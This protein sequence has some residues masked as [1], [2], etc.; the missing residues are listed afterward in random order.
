[1]PLVN[2]FLLRK[3]FLSIS[4]VHFSA[5]WLCLLEGTNCDFRLRLTA[6]TW[7]IKLSKGV[8]WAT[9][10]LVYNNLYESL[11]KPP[12]CSFLLKLFNCALVLFHGGN[13]RKIL[14]FQLLPFFINWFFVFWISLESTRICELSAT[15]G[16]KKVNKDKG[17][18]FWRFKYFSSILW[19]GSKH[20]CKAHFAING[21]SIAGKTTHSKSVHKKLVSEAE[22]GP[23]NRL[24]LEM[25]ELRADVLLLLANFI[26]KLKVLH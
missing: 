1:M 17:G 12:S 24:L 21:L 6:E 2:W 5:S 25:S 14:T 18:A 3:L 7:S 8:V 26:N 9:R 10:M 4:S 22:R 19:P 23:C 13:S 11:I 16:R 15:P 20:F